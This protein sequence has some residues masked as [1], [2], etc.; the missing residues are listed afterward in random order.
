VPVAVR[1]VPP[2]MVWEFTLIR[3]GHSDRVTWFLPGEQQ[4]G[5]V[6]GG[7]RRF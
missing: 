5:G 3:G 2:T 1:A 6:R 4:L 7:T